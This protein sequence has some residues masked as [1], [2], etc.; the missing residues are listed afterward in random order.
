MG[1][2]CNRCS[3]IKSHDL[4]SISRSNKGGYSHLC[5]VCVVQRNMEY[6]RTPIGRMSQT[7]A[8]QAVNSRQR[9]HP[10]PAYSR[11]ELTEWAINQGLFTLADA[12]RDSGYKKELSP[13]VDRHDPNQGYTLENIRLV[14]WAENNEKAYEDRKSCKHVTRQN[15]KVRQL[16]LDGTTIKIFDSVASASRETGIQRTNINAMCSGKPQYKSVGGFLWEYA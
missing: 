16:A 6:W 4:F 11:K 8:V 13:S 1:K 10:P 2:L 15:R 14:T 12:W 3:E 7:Y 9:K 5:K